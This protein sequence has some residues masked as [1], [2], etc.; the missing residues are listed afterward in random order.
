MILRAVGRRHHSGAPRTAFVPPRP[1]VRLLCGRLLDAEPR[2]RSR[3]GSLAYY[4]QANGV[5]HRSAAL[6]RPAFR[7]ALRIR[8]PRHL[9]SSFA[10]RCLRPRKQTGPFDPSRSSP[11]FIH[12]TW[13]SVERYAQEFA[14]AAVEQG[15]TVNVVTTASVRRCEVRVEDN[16]VNVLR[17]PAR[18]VSISGS[19][20]PIPTAGARQMA[21]FLQCDAVIAHTRFFLTVRIMA[22]GLCALRGKRISVFEHGSGPLRSQKTFVMASMGYEHAI[23]LLFRLFAPRFYAVFLPRLTGC[24]IFISPRPRSFR[25]V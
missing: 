18:R 2:A 17:L 15:V 19:Y 11:R 4:L 9:T 13:R 16:G 14:R 24:A 3:R 5:G 20:F 22:A 10:A 8:V 1:Q 25:M 21:A 12:R 7:A 23:T 6:T